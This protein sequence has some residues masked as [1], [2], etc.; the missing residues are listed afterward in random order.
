MGQETRCV[1]A[2][3]DEFKEAELGDRRLEQRLNRI[4]TAV[5]AA[6]SKGFPQVMA[7]EAELEGLY[8]FL[9][10]ERVSWKQILAP[11]QEATGERCRAEQLV[12]VAHDTTELAFGGKERANDIGHL[13]GGHAGFLAHVALAVAVERHRTP[14]GVLGLTTVHREKAEKITPAQEQARLRAKPQHEKENHRGNQ[15]ADASAE[16]IPGVS[17]VHVMDR[18]ADDFVVLAELMKRNH[19]FVI[20]AWSDRQLLTE[21]GSSLR[22]RAA[23]NQTPDVLFREVPLSVRR[24]K[25][26][27]SAK[28]RHPARECRTA[29]LHIRARSVTVLPPER[30][31]KGLEP[32]ELNA[33]EVFEPV[34]AEDEAP[35]S[36]M[37]LT[38]EPIETAEQRARVVDCYRCRWPTLRS[39]LSESWWR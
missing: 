7:S 36:W 26:A 9:G 3:R 32:L 16:L 24:P 4:V 8:R 17:C 34:P 13:Q 29:T 27:G 30:I 23:L 33:V 21:S 31:N 18:E 22:L 1:P 12:V 38:T 11:H 19:R 15:L 35:I 5:S 37:L 6:P 10:N 39:R 20:R 25:A 28:K 2:V 14:L